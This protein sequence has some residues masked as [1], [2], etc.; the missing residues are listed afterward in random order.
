MFRGFLQLDMSE[1]LFPIIQIY[2]WLTFIFFGYMELL[3][4]CLSLGTAV[5]S[6]TLTGKLIR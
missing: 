6:T 5:V 4:I 3:V 2:G 1:S